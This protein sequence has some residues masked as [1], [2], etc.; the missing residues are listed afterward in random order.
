LE[1][2]EEKAGVVVATAHPS[3]ILAR[4]FS[5]LGPTAIV[6]ELLMGI[7]AGTFLL[8][9]IG[10]VVACVKLARTLTSTVH[11][12]H[13]G[14][15]KVEAGD[16]THRIPVRSNDQLSEL[17][18]SFNG[19]TKHIEELIEDVKEKEKLESEL[20]IARQVQTQLF[21]KE[22]P[23]LA[24]LELAGVCNPARVV[25]GD[26]YDFIPLDSRGVAIVIGD[27]SGKGISAALLMAAV[28]ASLHAQL[29]MN[30][31]HDVSTSTLVTR[32]N[33]QLY[34]NTPPEKYA[35]FYCAVYD[36]TKS[37][38]SYTNA[39]HLAPILVRGGDVL[40][41]ESNGTVVGMFPDYPFEQ[42]D[43]ELQSGDLLAAFTDGI[44]ESENANEEQFGE[45]RLIDL[46][47]RDAKK[48]LKEI[49]QNVM[50]AVENWAH[51]PSI[52]DDITILLARK[53]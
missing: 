37:R 9:E 15:K 17:A 32:L 26:Y 53:L 10:A 8:V 19:M 43:V 50:N 35:T 40:R 47:K 18:A 21:P 33:R 51:D 2:G 3:A 36:E 27:I 45:G 7:I 20:E 22:V 34:E 28:Q 23:K 49:I 44:T 52:R 41:L 5:T 6:I 46:L 48:P 39:G 16:F 31:E 38:L 1:N 30:S 4:I 24:T 42:S 29:S 12:L 14:T 25:S 11:D 13:Q